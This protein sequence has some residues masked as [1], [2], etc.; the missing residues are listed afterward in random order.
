VPSRHQ[1]TEAGVSKISSTTGRPIAGND[2]NS[3]VDFTDFAEEK[4][5]HA[6]AGPAMFSA[7]KSA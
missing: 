7:A 1:E 5:I 3:S 2:Q 4:P 6:T